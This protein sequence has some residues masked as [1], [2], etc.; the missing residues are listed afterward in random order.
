MRLYKGTPFALLVTGAL[1]AQAPR[2]HDSAGV[3]IVENP[4]RLTAPIVFQLGKPTFDAGGLQQHPDDELSTRNGYPRA[5]RAPNG[6][7]IILDRTRV[8]F[9]ASSG[10]RIKSFGRQG[11]GPGEFDPATDVCVTHGDTVLVAQERKPLT[12]LTKDGALID[13][14]PLPDASYAESAICLDDGTFIVQHRI[15]FTPTTVYR[16]TRMSPAKAL[17]T[18]VDF[19]YPE[20][21][22]LIRSETPR[23]ARGRTLFIATA[24]EFSIRAYDE[25]GGL[26]SIIRTA[27]VLKPITDAEKMKLQPMAVR[28][29]SGPAEREAQQKR[30]VAASKTKF[31]PTVG[32]MY[33]DLD[34]RLWLEDWRQPEDPTVPDGW[35]A[36]DSTGRLLGRLILPAATKESR[37]HVVSFSKDE[38]IVYRLDDDGA[39]HYTAYAIQSV[40]K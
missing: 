1:Q 21:D 29:G 25:A 38:V 35:T 37:R 20:F 19:Q 4:P 7:V 17:N 6:N 34:G 5:M 3:R 16:F 14:I 23:A 10:K 11:Q 22:M 32:K 24:N 39:V 36:F 30:A 33:V 27:D 12:R 28:M 9:Y 13:V 2:V 40:R 18:I 8:L 15:S 26:R 31:W